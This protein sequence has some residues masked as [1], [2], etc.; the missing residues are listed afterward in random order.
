MA[1]L[2]LIKPHPGNVFRL[3][4]G[5]NE[6]ATDPLP[7]FLGSGAGRVAG[8]EEGLGV[9]VGAGG[10]LTD[11]GRGHVNTAAVGQAVLV[12]RVPARQTV[13]IIKVLKVL[14]VLIH[15]IDVNH[16]VLGNLTD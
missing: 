2:G 13:D 16:I 11:G 6:V 14:P 3:P 10:Q 12:Y 9:G 7:L 1:G 15:L 8:V 4:L 5:V